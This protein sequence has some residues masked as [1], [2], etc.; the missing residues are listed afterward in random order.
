[1][2]FFFSVLVGLAVGAL[3]GALLGFLLEQVSGQQGWQLVVGSI[4]A[5]VGAFWAGLRRASGAP[6][7]R[8]RSR[9]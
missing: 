4:V 3:A 7:W 9:S 2:R 8:V 5:N 1:M 6:V